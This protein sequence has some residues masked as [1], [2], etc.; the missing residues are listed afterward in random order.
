MR[1]LFD[2]GTPVPLRKYLK[3]HTVSTAYEMGWSTLRNGELL[4]VAAVQ[5]DAFITTDQKLKHEQKL[6]GQHLAILVLPFASWP[7]L[8]NHVSKIASAVDSLQP[9]DYVELD[10]N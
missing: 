1:I 6:G 4:R 9:G 8:Q 7:K 2:Q 3:I 5:F 10:L